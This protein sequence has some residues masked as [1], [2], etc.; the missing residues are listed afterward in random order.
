MPER[1][2][3]LWSRPSGR[4][5]LLVATG[6]LLLAGFG[7]L[8]W[9]LL[10]LRTDRVLT[11]LWVSGGL[12]AFFGAVGVSV[13]WKWLAE[14]KLDG[15][16]VSPH[17]LLVKD[18]ARYRIAARAEIHELVCQGG[19]LTVVYGPERRSWRQYSARAGT[20]AAG[21]IEQR[22]R[23]LTQWH[24]SGVLPPPQGPRDPQRA[25]RPTH[26][27]AL[28]IL[29]IVTALLGFLWLTLVMP[30]R[31]DAGRIARAFVA[32]VR[33]GEYDAAYALL[34]TE[35]KRSLGRDQ[36]EATLPPKLRSASGF[37]VNSMSTGVGTVVGSETCIDGWLD[38][39]SGY[40]GYAFDMIVESDA[41][42]IETYREGTCRK[43]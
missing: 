8:V 29:A 14:P 16:L 33:A 42:R 6:A 32:H 25:P 19:Q 12:L 35:R 43:R 7:L 5:L 22:G 34:S 20:A 41:L 15:L 2:L 28:T 24:T 1:G 9:A 40:S 10:A 23:A 37:T 13:V 39:V 27:L 21:I 4:G 31:S 36:F 11:P 26:K 3:G 17:G 30:A 18:G 38:D